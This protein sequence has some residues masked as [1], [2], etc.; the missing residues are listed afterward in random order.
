MTYDQ[1]ISKMIVDRIVD[2][3]QSEFWIDRS[4][5]VHKLDVDEW[6][7]DHEGEDILSF[8]YEIVRQK[9]PAWKDEDIPNKLGWISFGTISGSRNRYDIEPNQ[10]QLN[11]IYKLR[12]DRKR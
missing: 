7:R 8:H 5:F 12:N 10:A 3:S 2:K 11:T 6:F 9:F 4:G 1:E